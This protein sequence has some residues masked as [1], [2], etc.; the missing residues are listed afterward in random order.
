MLKTLLGALACSLLFLGCGNSAK[1]EA[2]PAN[3]EQIDAYLDQLKPLLQKV[4]SLD[5][6]IARAVPTDSVSA[7]VIVPLIEARFRP[8]LLELSAQVQKIAPAPELTTAH[9]HLRDYLRLRLE[10]FDLAVRGA[11]QG[12]PE[13]FELFGERLDAADEAGRA[14]KSA[15]DE[16]RYGLGR[17]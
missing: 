15:L 5:V 1:E 17:F 11:R 10:A 9:N 16:A 12:Q 14:L 6:E 4:R 8:K 2:P 7:D 13:L 3:T